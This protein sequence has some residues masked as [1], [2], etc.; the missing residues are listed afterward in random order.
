[1]FAGANVLADEGCSRHCYTLHREQDELVQF[2]VAAPA[3]H[4]ARAKEIDIGLHEH[5]GERGERGLDAGRD[6]DAEHVDQYLPVKIQIP[7]DEFVDFVRLDQE[8]HGE[9]GGD[10]L[11]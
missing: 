1:M 11:G 7:P 6:C 3:G 2:I 4:A 10:H 9:D 5:I 8:A